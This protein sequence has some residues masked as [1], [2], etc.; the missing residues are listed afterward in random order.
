VSVHP[1]SKATGDCDGCGE[2]IENGDYRFTVVLQD[3]LSF[4]FHD[5][6]FDV[7]N[8]FGYRSR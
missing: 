6:C 5:E 3:G 7:Y 1:G 2:R 4:Q 8:T